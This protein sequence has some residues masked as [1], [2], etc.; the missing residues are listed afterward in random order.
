MLLRLLDRSAGELWDS[1][2]GTWLP[3]P[4][5]LGLLLVGVRELWE[6]SR[7]DC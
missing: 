4:G 7:L 1:S 5:L 3:R 6:V 2:D